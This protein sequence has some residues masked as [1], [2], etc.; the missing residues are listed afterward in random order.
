MLGTSNMVVCLKINKK[1]CNN[2]IS[3]DWGT[4]KIKLFYI[5]IDD[6]VKRKRNIES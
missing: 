4:I 2:K 1:N 6:K 3:I 5:F